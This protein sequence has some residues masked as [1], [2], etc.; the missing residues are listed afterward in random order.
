MKK[1]VIIGIVAV[2][3][4]LVIIGIFIFSPEKECKTADDC[5][6]KSCFTVQC[7]SNSCIYSPI[8]DCCGNEICEAGENYLGCAVDCQD[9]D[10]NNECT[11]DEYDYHEQKCVNKPILDVVCCGNGI[12]ELEETYE[13]CV[14][15]C[16]NCDDENQCTEDSYDYHKQNC[17]NEPIIPCCGNGIC[18]ENV[19]TNLDCSVDCPNCD[20]DNKL[21]IDS[22]NYQTQKCENPVTH[23]FFDDFENGTENWEFSEPMVWNTIVEDGN[24]VLRGTHLSRAKLKNKNLTNYILKVRFKIIEGGI[25]LHYRFSTEEGFPPYVVHLEDGNVILGLEGEEEVVK[26]YSMGKKWHTFEIRCYDNIVNV[27]I[28]DELLIKSKYGEIPPLSSGVEFR[29]Y[30]MSEIL[31]DDVEIKLITEKDII[32]P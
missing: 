23:Y 13:N 6:T 31:I 5:L 25:H 9:C 32:Y 19:E 21:T 2:V 26:K 11:L 8:S 16:P 30:G 15:D 27:Y 18:D 1:G 29:N 3:I 17:T 10:D 24:T 4:V 14:V 12:C 7:E 22:F 20:D 28:D